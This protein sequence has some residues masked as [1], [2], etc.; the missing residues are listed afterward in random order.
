MKALKRRK[1]CLV[2][3]WIFAGI[4]LANTP[5]HAQETAGPAAA[6]DQT[7]IDLE[8]E[9]DRLLALVT[10]SRENKQWQQSLEA[11]D[12]LENLFDEY[13]VW[14]ELEP[15]DLRSVR[16][17]IA[18]WRADA[19]IVLK[20]PHVAKAQ[21]EVAL[22][23]N[24]GSNDDGEIEKY[25][26][27]QLEQLAVLNIDQYALNELKNQDRTG[28]NDEQKAASASLEKFMG[29]LSE[30]RKAYSERRWTEMEF[31]AGEIEAFFQ[32]PETLAESDP[33]DVEEMKKYVALF[34]ADAAVQLGGYERAEEQYGI[35]IGYFL[36]SEPD[37]IQTVTTRLKL[38]AL[39]REQGR[40]KEALKIFSEIEPQ[41]RKNFP[42]DTASFASL[43]GQIGETYFVGG[44]Y[45]AAERYFSDSLNLYEKA[46][47]PVPMD[48]ELGRV[49]LGKTYMGQGRWS[50]AEALFDTALTN[51]RSIL[52][53]D[54]DHVATALSGLVTIYTETGRGAEAE[55]LARQALATFTRTRGPDYPGTIR[56]LSNLAVSLIFQNRLID[57]EGYLQQALAS[58]IRA[59]GTDH[60]QTA[61]ISSNLG[62]ALGRMERFED[63]LPHLENARKWLEAAAGPDHPEISVYQNN[64]AA[65]LMRL[66]RFPE[67]AAMAEESIRTMERVL[68]PDHP[69]LAINWANYGGVLFLGK[70][71][72]DQAITAFERALEIADAIPGE[73]GWA[74][75]EALNGISLALGTKDS[76]SNRALETGRRAVELMRQQRAR[77]LDADSL[78]QK[79][80]ATGMDTNNEAMSYGRISYAL[81]IKLLSERV[82]EL[83]K[84][85]GQHG[86][87]I[88][89]LAQDFKLSGSARAMAQTAARTASGTGDLANLVR[90]QQDL[91][92][93]LV[94]N[95][96]ELE[97]ALVS[98]D[99]DRTEQITKLVKDI[100]S[101]LDATNQQLDSQFPDYAE[102]INPD[103]LNIEKVQSRLDENDAL[104]LIHSGFQ[105]VVIF[106]VTKQEVLWTNQSGVEKDVKS[107]ISRLRCQ[108]DPQGCDEN[109]FAD[110]E[111]SDSELEGYRPFDRNAAFYLYQEL[112]EPVEKLLEDKEHIYVVSDGALAT[113]PLA[114]LVAEKPEVGDDADPKILSQ[115]VWLGEKYAFTSLP[116]VSALNGVKADLDQIGADVPTKDWQ[117]TG[118]GAPLLDGPVSDKTAV[119]GTGSSG[120]FRASGNVGLSLA[121][122]SSIKKLIPLPGTDREL[123]AMATALQAGSDAVVTGA[124]AT[125]TAVRTSSRLSKSQVVIFA[126]HGLLPEELDGLNEPALVFTP[127]ERATSLDDG[128]LSASEATEL[129]LDA[130][131][132]I[133]S[134]CNTASAEGQGGG[135]SLS[136]LSRAFLYAGTKSLLASNWR[137]GDEETAI[138]TVETIKADQGA[139]NR[140]RALALKD[141]MQAVRTGKRVNGT[142]IP[143]WNPEWVHPASWA[144]FIHISNAR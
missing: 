139:P 102:L 142:D 128:V 60:Q 39:Y 112:I 1:F 50:E 37:S 45:A 12:S 119:R 56:S 144:S 84:E 80:G 66:K 78:A 137:V 79:A 38:A 141:A 110:E 129:K 28:L 114:A 19:L 10:S 97:K 53:E 31:H 17:N 13:A 109:Y 127:P 121:D 42:T 118:F 25:L 51:L 36:K 116:A 91:S 115:T 123:E 40:L 86:D 55:P 11:A 49:N 32:K 99:L 108:I 96:A 93:Q 54:H 58:A 89:V 77:Q 3:I 122:P 23:F 106:A 27:S 35:A 132:V 72:R 90:Q 130:R 70:Q 48:T 133:L 113:L 20:R 73:P 41:Y 61:Q 88:F 30:I 44:D 34:R 100:A 74:V 101:K 57:A 22:K 120:F 71:D 21:Y 24:E 33:A 15:I 46:R 18:M 104:L 9:V 2:A 52:G 107:K 64:I 81:L 138:L 16:R 98:G 8:T 111:M 47:D 5:S 43:M 92:R 140:G 135:D 125:E 126:T 7:A 26:S 14:P 85:Q 94:I 62:T 124:A 59:L 65:T 75:I 87:E 131:W 143:E 103:P 69:K 134:A 63:A 6:E 105:D 4:F 117:F 95:D 68:G 136:S 67:A 83:P 29:H 82:E 76:T